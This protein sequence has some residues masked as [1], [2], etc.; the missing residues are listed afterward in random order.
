[1]GS[2]QWAPSQPLS[3]TSPCLQ[4]CLI[5]LCSTF[6]FIGK[7]AEHPSP[8]KAL[9]LI[10]NGLSRLGSTHSKLPCNSLKLDMRNVC[11]FSQGGIKDRRLFVFSSRWL[12]SSCGSHD[13]LGAIE[14]SI[15]DEE[16]NEERGE[17][18]FSE[19]IVEPTIP[20]TI[21]DGQF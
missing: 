10:S 21:C 11:W 9:T 5:D 6:T 1:M 7:K 20:G 2:S 15:H 17:N 16:E 12:S 13:S 18:L 8:T 4:T 3:S 19:T 14:E